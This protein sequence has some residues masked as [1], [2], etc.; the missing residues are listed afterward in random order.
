MIGFQLQT[1][2]GQRGND[3]SWDSSAPVYVGIDWGNLENGSL[4]Y[5]HSEEIN[6][7]MVLGQGEGTD[8]EIVLVSDTA[9]IGASIW[10]RREGAKDARNID[11]GDTT[12]LT[13]EGNTYL[14]EHKPT[15][16]FTGDIVETPAFRYGKDW[17]FGDKVTLV[18]A[19]IE[20]D[21][22]INKVMVSRGDDGQETITARLEL[23]E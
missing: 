3:R 11:K 1:F 4:E 9:R 8:R 22:N 21:C 15:M 5:D 6:Y 23:N 14:T 12:A 17:W 7:A 16:K 19:G 10:N 18:Y 20:K 13:G 2:T